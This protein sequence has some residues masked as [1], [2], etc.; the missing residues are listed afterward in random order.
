[1]ARGLHRVTTAA[2]HSSGRLVAF[3]QIGG[4]ATSS[5]FADQGDTIVALNLT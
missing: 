2:V 4:Y 3:T 1:V 5:W